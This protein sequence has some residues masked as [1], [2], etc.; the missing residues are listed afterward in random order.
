MHKTV[1]HLRRKDFD[2]DGNLLAWHGNKTIIVMIYASWC[3]FCKVAFP[4]YVK[5]ASMNSNRNLIFAAIKADGEVEGERECENLFEKI[6]PGFEGFPDYGVI[7]PT[8]KKS[9]RFDAKSR[10]FKDVLD[11]ANKYVF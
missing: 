9:V 1:I 6:I 7:L 4:E 2:C 11:S 3:G 8:S 10:T 5:A